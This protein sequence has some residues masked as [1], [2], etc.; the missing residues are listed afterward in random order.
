MRVKICGITQPQQSV[1]IANLGATALGFIC[2]STSPRYVTTQQIRAAVAQL[3]PNIDRI[4]V[5]ANRTIAEI[6]QIV[7]DSGLTGVQLHGE[8]PPE[9]CSLLRQNL[10]NVEIIKAFR[11]RSLEHLAQ[12][13]NYTEHI[14]TLLLDAYHPQQLGGTGHTLDWQMLQQFQ[15][16]CPWLLA[17]GLS[18]D[19]VLAAL[20]QV[21]PDGIDLSSGVEL[22]P[23][24]K[25]LDQVALLFEKLA[26]RNQGGRLSLPNPHSPISSP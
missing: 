15:P 3:P 4:G 11:V 6:R 10:A 2:V 16:S 13:S 19:N 25:D 26:T 24:D 22:K 8:E 21:K 17:G 23:G 1:A 18:P 7:M 5:F 14:D 9:F 20:N 12:A